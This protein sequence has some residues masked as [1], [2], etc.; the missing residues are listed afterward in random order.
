MALLT[1]EYPQADRKMMRQ[2]INI[3]DGTIKDLRGVFEIV[4]PNMR[5]RLSIVFRRMAE[6]ITNRAWPKLSEKYAK[7]KD[8]NYP[9]KRILERS[10]D[11]RRA[12]SKKGARGQVVIMKKQG[13]VFGVDGLGIYPLVHQVTSRVRNDGVAYRRTWFGFAL[14][15]LA[16]MFEMAIVEVVRKKFKRVRGARFRK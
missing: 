13:M 10:G 3:L 11:L 4:I 12:A 9:G 8:E 14:K 5:Q 6:P 2:T 7:W 15:V 1:I 16:M